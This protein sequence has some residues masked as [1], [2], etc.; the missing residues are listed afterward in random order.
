MSAI[1][2][3]YSGSKSDECWGSAHRGLI[4]SGNPSHGK[5]HPHLEWDFTIHLKLS[6]NAPRDDICRV[7][8]L[9]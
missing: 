2:D 7:L 3:L 5:M 1:L 4:Q 8:F 9:R 6:G